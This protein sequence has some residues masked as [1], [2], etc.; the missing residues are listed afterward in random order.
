VLDLIV[1]S[2]L[3][4]RLLIEVKRMLSHRTQTILKSIVG[5]YI[6]K[7]VPVASQSIVDDH[8]LGVSPATIRSEMAHLEQEGY[9]IRQHPS[10]GSVP[11]D[12]GYRYYVESLGDI[13][14]PLAEQRLIRHLFH[15]VERELE[16]WLR[17]AAKVIAQLVQNIAVVTIPKTVHCQFKYLELVSLQE[18]LALVIF[19]LRGARVK[20][21]LIAFDQ[22]MS[23]PKL[24]AIANK[25]NTAYS[26]LTRSGILAKNIELS[27]TEQQLT[28]Y[29]V[30]VMQTEDEQEYEEPYLNGLHFILGQPEFTSRQRMKSLLELVDHR[31]LLK[32]IAPQGL[33]NQE[34]RVVIGKENKAE[35]I[36][37]YSVVISRYGLPDGAVGTIGVIGPTRMPY[38]R[39]ISTVSYLSS[40]LSGLAAELYGQEFV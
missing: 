37:D 8:E 36:Q 11:S 27:P 20:Q 12:K 14:L 25:L 6:V 28:D 1:I 26:G 17:L 15:Q 13:E 24:M 33:T 32:I 2:N 16:E 7:A 4:L 29:L 35:V 34:M 22:V 40:V 5:Q 38:A 3:G 18:L 30:K 10:A 31:S 23:Q 9:I 21:R 39:A 19:V